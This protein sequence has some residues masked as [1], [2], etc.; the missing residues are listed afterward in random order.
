LRD[1][2][3]VF[4]FGP[5]QVRAA[6]QVL[7]R[8]GVIVPLTPK[9]YGVLWALIR[10]NGRVVDKESL[11]GEVWP[12]SFV[13]EGN[14]A[15]NIFILRRAL[16]EMQG[17]GRYIETVPKR[18]YRFVGRVKHQT[19]AAPNAASQIPDPERYTSAFDQN[20]SLPAGHDAVS[21]RPG[22]RRWAPRLA[23]SAAALGITFALASRVLPLH[24]QSIDI[25]Q[26]KL[27]ID[28]N[29][30]YGVI[31]PDGSSIAYISADPE[32]QSVWVRELGASGIGMRISNPAAGHHWGLTYS[33]SGEQVYYVFEDD[34]RPTRGSLYRIPAA[35]GQTQHVLDDI[36]TVPAFRGDGK[37]MVFKRF[38]AGT[39][40]AL[41]IRANSEGTEQQV[42]SSSQAD[43]PF[44]AVQWAAD[45]KTIRYVSGSR[46]AE[47]TAWRLA[48][49]PAGGGPERQFARDQIHDIR[50][51]RWVDRENLVV[52]MRDGAS[53]P[54]QVW[55]LKTNGR[56]RRL[57]NDGNSYSDISLTAGGLLALQTETQDSLWSAS[58]AADGTVQS[59]AIPR[60]GHGGYDTPEWT[61]DGQLLYIYGPLGVKPELWRTD[62]SGNRRRPLIGYPT[63][64][65]QPSCSSDGQTLAF[66][67]ESNGSKNI[68][69][70]DSEKGHVRRLTT[71]VADNY[72][73][74]STDG[75]WVAYASK[76]NGLWG[77]W[78]IRTDGQSG[79]VQIA[80]SP[81]TIPAI[82]P[83]GTLIAHEQT[84]PANRQKCAAIRSFED[85]S[86]Q[87]VLPLPPGV[88]NLKWRRDGRTLTFVTHQNG[89][90]RIWS[91]PLSGGAPAII[92]RDLP[93]DMRGMDWAWDGTRIAYL[94]RHLKV[95]LV[96]L[97]GTR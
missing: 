72:P 75:K 92:V 77:I 83:D 15:Q 60:L 6:E 31:S 3:E 57:T 56:L 29:V 4:E 69:V 20:A 67:V 39:G 84:N 86:L 35:G 85:G 97:E 27:N 9:A 81:E 54:F 19:A 91:L 90:A 59:S 16:G 1:S 42:I 89:S 66:V 63:D 61:P 12:D 14:L 53:Q 93:N 17:G 47:G 43:L 11:L 22:F 45:G 30:S 24:P 71:G 49:I 50:C 23:L 32:V 28:N 37:S 62:L 76:V 10:R 44:H 40:R 38:D 2:E 51:A 21:V 87:K 82:S 74:C 80:A 68:W 58:V 94:R 78:K 73:Q 48:E 55:N 18:G 36:A 26:S 95:D 65:T 52:V 33:P 46:R 70:A 7:F 96:R 34:R 13:D 25:R 64:I 8:A 5:F 41:L 79:P 88:D